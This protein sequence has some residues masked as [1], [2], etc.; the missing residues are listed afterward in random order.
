M[1]YTNLFNPTEFP[2][3][4]PGPPA[5]KYT[6]GKYSNSDDLSATLNAF[7]AYERDEPRRMFALGT[8]STRTIPL[9]VPDGPFEFGYAVDACWKKVDGEVTDPVADFPPDA[10]CLEPYRLEVCRPAIKTSSESLQAVEH[11]V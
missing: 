4:L 2:E 3:T 10:N 11:A 7:V 5:F 1:H 6:P 8:L 9:R